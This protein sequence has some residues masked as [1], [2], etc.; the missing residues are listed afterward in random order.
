VIDFN[1]PERRGRFVVLD[2]LRGSVGRAHSHTLAV[3]LAGPASGLAA[4][5][6]IAGM[7]AFLVG[8]GIGGG[9]ATLVRATTYTTQQVAFDDDAYA[10]SSIYVV[11]NPNTGMSGCS[12]Q[13]GQSPPSECFNTPWTFNHAYNWWYY[14]TPLVYQYHSANCANG[15][16]TY[17]NFAI[18]GGSTPW[19][20]YSTYDGG[21]TC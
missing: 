21:Y 16:F 2:K 3:K 8:A 11:C 15:W 18:S 1:V 14:G 10:T 17:E 9:T 19:Y 6:V 13:N 7:V 5:S 4:R 12:N 20:C